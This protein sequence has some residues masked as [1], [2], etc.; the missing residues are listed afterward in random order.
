M[1]RF[2]L[3]PGKTKQILCYIS[4]ICKLDHRHYCHVFISQVYRNV[5]PPL[6]AIDNFEGTSREI[7]EAEPHR[8]LK[9]A[10][11]CSH[12]QTHHCQPLHGGQEDAE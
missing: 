9:R 11:I 8:Y 5:N 10:K 1:Y 2:I 7:Y 4:K 6:K 12:W 3:F